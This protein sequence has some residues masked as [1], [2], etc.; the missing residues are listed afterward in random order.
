[1]R[2]ILVLMMLA[3]SIGCFA[4]KNLNYSKVIPCEGVNAE[5]AYLRI[6]LWAVNLF[7]SPNKN[8]QLRDKE[9][10]TLVIKAA[11]V[12]KSEKG[13]AG[14]INGYIN[15]TLNLFFR[16]GRFKVEMIDMEHS[17]KKRHIQFWD[18]Y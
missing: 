8:V 2:N 14:D 15:Y 18:T 13:N 11:T 17:G 6:E 9:N 4:Q 7:N 10:K 16:D 5:E 1:M 12:F 3:V